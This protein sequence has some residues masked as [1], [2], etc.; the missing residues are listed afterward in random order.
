MFTV[1]PWGEV[2]VDGKHVGTAPPLYKFPAS[3]GRHRIEIQNPEF[4]THAQTVELQPG[5]QVD[6][7]HIFLP[8][9]HPNPFQFLW[10]K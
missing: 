6:V 3:P 2:Y 5:G 7:R 8:K 4:P 1:K 9:E 10:K